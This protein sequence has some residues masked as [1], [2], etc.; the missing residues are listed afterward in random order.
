[1]PANLRRFAER[2]SVAVSRCL[3][4]TYARK[5]FPSTCRNYFFMPSPANFLL[6]FA[7]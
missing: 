4:P 1:M 6:N 7:T 5:P 2:E 3:Q